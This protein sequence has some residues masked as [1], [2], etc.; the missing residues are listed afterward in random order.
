METCVFIAV[1]VV[2]G[3]YGGRFPDEKAC[4]LSNKTREKNVCRS[5]M[6]ELSTEMARVAEVG[7]G[8]FVMKQESDRS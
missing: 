8:N 5:R 7:R 3:L 6:I 2:V 4:C 1:V